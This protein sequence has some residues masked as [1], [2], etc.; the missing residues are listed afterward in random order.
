M[1]DTEVMPKSSACQSVFA[2]Q[3]GACG[4]LEHHTAQ[5]TIGWEDGALGYNWIH[6]STRLSY[7]ASLFFLP[8]YYHL[9]RETRVAVIASSHIII[10]NLT[11]ATKPPTHITHTMAIPPQTSISDQLEQAAQAS[12]SEPAKAEELYREILSRKAG[13]SVARVEV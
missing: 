6:I 8:I 5:A 12:K 11:I 1:H 4:Q 3:S 2:R 13:E 10:Y 7:H 9:I